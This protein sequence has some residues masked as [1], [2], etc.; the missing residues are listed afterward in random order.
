MRLAARASPARVAKATVITKP[1]IPS[2][3]H[4]SA[5]VRP[6]FPADVVLDDVELEL[7][8]VFEFELEFELEFDCADATPASDSVITTARS[9]PATSRRAIIP[10]VRTLSLS[11]KRVYLVGPEFVADTPNSCSSLVL[12]GYRSSF[13]GHP[14]RIRQCRKV[15]PL[16][17]GAWPM[18]SSPAMSPIKIVLVV[19]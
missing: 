9:A 8:L 5:P 16:A 13:E 19:T 18:A 3:T 6:R 14:S 11:P 17:H 15:I 12:V 4:I 2:G 10:V 1:P 7:V